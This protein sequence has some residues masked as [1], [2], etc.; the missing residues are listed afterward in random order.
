VEVR[1]G[2]EAVSQ[3]VPFDHQ[4][5]GDVQQRA[6]REPAGVEAPPDEDAGGQVFT[7]RSPLGNRGI[8][9][10]YQGRT[11]QLAGDAVEL[12]SSFRRVGDYKGF[13]VYE[14]QPAGERQIYVVSRDNVVA[15][16]R[17]AE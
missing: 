14:K 6:S 8:W 3:A 17:L 15:P 12:D 1:P 10:M 16:Y 9:I 13:A 5:E 4:A 2:A 11:W 7:A